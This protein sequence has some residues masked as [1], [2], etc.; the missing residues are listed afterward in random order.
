MFGVLTLKNKKFV[1]S[2]SKSFVVA[3][4]IRTYK[5][6]RNLSWPR[7]KLC[8]VFGSPK[9]YKSGLKGQVNMG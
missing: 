3:R 1:T 8:C 7:S 2:I 5:L 6:L 9:I 4:M